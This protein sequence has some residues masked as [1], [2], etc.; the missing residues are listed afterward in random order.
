VVTFPAVVSSESGLIQQDR[1]DEAGSLGLGLE[2]GYEPDTDLG[3][4]RAESDAA[5]EATASSVGPPSS[6]RDL[7]SKFDFIR[8]IKC[9]FSGLQE[10]HSSRLSAVFVRIIHRLP[11]LLP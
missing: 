9:V 8:I 1:Q 7:Y 10:M 4:R 3:H 5:S 6:V 2:Y 11:T